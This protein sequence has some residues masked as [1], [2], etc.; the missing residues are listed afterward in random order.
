MLSFIYFGQAFEPANRKPSVKVLSLYDIPDKTIK[1]ISTK[2]MNNM[3]PIK[4]AG[5]VSSSCQKLSKVPHL[6][7]FLRCISA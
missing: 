2:Y 4:V 3:D 7:G 5:D 6:C 1:V